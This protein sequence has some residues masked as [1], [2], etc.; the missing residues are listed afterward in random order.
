MRLRGQSPHKTGPSEIF[1][2]FWHARLPRKDGRLLRKQARARH[3]VRWHPALG[4]PSLQ[5][6]GKDISVVSKPPNLWHSVSQPEWAKTALRAR[7]NRNTGPAAW[8]VIRE[9]QV[10]RC[11]E[12]NPHLR[13]LFIPIYKCSNT[14]ASIQ[15]DKPTHKET[16]CQ[17]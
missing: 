4:L 10:S 13:P 17:K 3:P 7:T 8:L 15:G 2:S 12:V 16:P 5:H 1:L 11:W 6:C 9:P 14:I